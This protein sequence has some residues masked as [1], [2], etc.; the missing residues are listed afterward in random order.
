MRARS[1]LLHCGTKQAKR[2]PPGVPIYIAIEQ[3]T[4]SYCSHVPTPWPARAPPR[5]VVSRSTSCWKQWKAVNYFCA[6]AA[7]NGPKL[8]RFE[9][10]QPRRAGSPALSPRRASTRRRRAATLRLVWKSTSE[11]TAHCGDNVASMAWGAGDDFHT[12]ALRPC[13]RPAAAR[14]TSAT[15]TPPPTKPSPP[16]PHA[17]ARRMPSTAQFG[18]S[19]PRPRAPRLRRSAARRR[20]RP[21]GPC[22]VDGAGERRDRGRVRGLSPLAGRAFALKTEAG[23]GRVWQWSIAGAARRVVGVPSRG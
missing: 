3:T 10:P 8:R 22:R 19:S 6:R 9:L 1:G 15:A 2:E 18:A 11:A 4:L 13:A 12:R 20:R 14:P 5:A 23:H 7:P 17:R 16:G 21:R